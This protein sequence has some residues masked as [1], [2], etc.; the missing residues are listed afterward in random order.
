[1]TLSYWLDGNFNLNSNELTDDTSFDVIIVGAG[2]AGLSTA[3][4][5]EKFNPGLQI[6]IV[7]KQT[8]GAGATGRNAGFVTCGSA[9]HFA[10]LEKQFGLQQAVSIWKFSETNRE[11]LKSEIIG[12]DAADLDFESTGSCTVAASDVDWIRYQNLFETMKSAG[13]DVELIDEKYL[14]EKYGV[15]NFLGAIQYNQDGAIHPIKLLQKIKSKLSTTKFLMNQNIV[16]LKHENK[17]WVVTTSQKKLYA[18][19]VISCLNG[20]TETFLPEFKT[21]V[22]P[23]RGQIILTEALKH[24]VKGPCYLTKHLCYFRQL[25]TGQ[26]LVG[27]FRNQDIEAENTNEDHITPKI[28]N[29]L[30]EFTHSYFQNCADVKIKYQWSGVMGFSPDN[31][32]I[33]GEIPNKKDLFIMAGCAGHG[34]G[35]SFHTAKVL[36]E[37][38]S[39]KPLPMNLDIQR[40]PSTT[41][42]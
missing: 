41:F 7:D 24:F 39:G 40:F 21:V 2:I 28:Q 32:M 12:D 22:K 42:G 1:M 23:Q 15:R 18:K 3:Y 17:N 4:W 37:N 14:S 6:L 38:I 33:V 20:F 9:E 30:K 27:G 36:V 10:K 5:L 26:L 31:Q 35:L 8:P 25:P 11:L 16:D 13:L 29:A 19:K 34:M